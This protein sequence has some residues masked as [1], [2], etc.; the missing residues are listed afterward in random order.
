MTNLSARQATIER[1]GAQILATINL[2]MSACDFV[3]LIGPNGAG[4]TTLLRALAGLEPLSSGECRFDEIPISALSPRERARKIAYLPQLR[5]VHWNIDVERLVSL[6]RYAYGSPDRL[7]GPDIAAVERALVAADAAHLRRRAVHR[8]SGGEQAR[9]HLARALAA[10]APALLA[11]EPAA[12]L[13]PR[14]QI[15]IMRI[16]RSRADAGALV[17]AAL[18]DLDLALQFATRVVLLDR[19]RIVAE[20]APGEVL[21]EKML[22]PVFGVRVRRVETGDGTI[23]RISA[24]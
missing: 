20:G 22:S 11:D 18:H 5:E 13:D 17:V 10:E 14:H 7:R 23:L 8:L 16:L 15:S 12:S 21:T 1:G 2:N 6:G 19:G 3:A 9:A 4:K 24:G